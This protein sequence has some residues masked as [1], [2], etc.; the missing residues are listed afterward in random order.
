MIAS[1][2]RLALIALLLFACTETAPANESPSIANTI[3]DHSL[4]IRADSTIDI[5][6]YF[7]D[8][9]GDTLSFGAVSRD[10]GIVRVSVAGSLLTMTA[11]DI[12]ATSE[13]EVWASDPDSAQAA[14]VFEATVINRPPVIDVPMPDRVLGARTDSTIDLSPY[15]MDP[16]GDALSYDAVSHDSTIAS[17]SVDGSL[18]TVTAGSALGASEIEVRAS[19]PDSAQAVQV[20][21]VTVINL[22]PVVR[23]TIPYHRLFPGADSTIGLSPYFTDPNGDTLSYVVRSSNPAAVSVSI[24]SSLLTL[25]AGETRGASEIEVRAI[26]PD[27]AQAVQLFRASVFSPSASWRETFDSAG[28]LNYWRLVIPDDGG[29]IEVDERDSVLVVDPPSGEHPTTYAAVDDIVGITRNWTAS[30]RFAQK[31]GSGAHDE[32]CSSFFVYTGD[33]T[34]PFWVLDIDYFDFWW[35]LYVITGDGYWELLYEDANIDDPPDV[36]EYLNVTLSFVNDTM[37]VIADDS[38]TLASFDVLDEGWWWDEDD[39]PPLGATGVALGAVDCAGDDPMSI[40][41]DSVEISEVN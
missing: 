32:V 11:G 35:Y 14:Q 26:D 6:K 7:E 38:T 36:G 21:E 28:S 8:P 20:F 31:S 37:T 24:E 2:Y 4:T 22:P 33:A 39:P 13:I 34:Y 5:S 40:M 25:T 18:L 41:Y 9:D 12:R 3:P 27:S 17:V 16:D 15:F 19:D 23:D 1:P 10:P 29:S 30:T